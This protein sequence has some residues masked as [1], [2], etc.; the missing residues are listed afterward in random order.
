M[1]RLVP[2]KGHSVFLKAA[3]SILARH[4][5]TYFFIVGDGVERPDLET[6]SNEMNIANNIRFLGLRN[7]IQAV[8][9]V[10]DIAAMASHS[11]NLPISILEYMAVGK[12]IVSTN[13]GGISE[14]L[15]D[16]KSGLLVEPR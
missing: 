8:L 10:F 6:L 11:E 5:A 14:L 7:D 12:P 2:C 9:P 15:I 4:P 13:V 1:G 16:G 3:Q